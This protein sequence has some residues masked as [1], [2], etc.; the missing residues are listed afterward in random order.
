M[1]RTLKMPRYC[2]WCTQIPMWRE[3]ASCHFPVPACVSYSA[4]FLVWNV[5]R[6]DFRVFTSNPNGFLWASLICLLHLIHHPLQFLGLPWKVWSYASVD[7]RKFL[8]FLHIYF[9][10]GRINIKHLQ[11]WAGRGRKGRAR[12]QLSPNRS[13]FVNFTLKT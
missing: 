10:N 2:C 6:S 7:L 12:R 1:K 11:G 13:C 5:C 3:F 4:F 9:F 8:I